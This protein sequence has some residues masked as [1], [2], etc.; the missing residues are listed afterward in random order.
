[1]SASSEKISNLVKKIS[2]IHGVDE[3]VISSD[4]KPDYDNF[5]KDSKLSFFTKNFNPKPGD[6]IVDVGCFIGSHLYAL[7]KKYPD[8]DF[9]G[10][11]IVPEYIE[12][13][14]AVHSS[15][16]CKFVCKN[17]LIPGVKQG[18]A[19][20]LFFFEVL[21]HVDSPKYYIDV[22][23]KILKK[24]GKLYLSTPAAIGITNILL[25]I[26]HQSFEYQESEQRDTGTE[27]DHIYIYGI[28]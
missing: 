16:N 14:K 19:D 25:N 13:A 12:L 22:F 8:C 26:K 27:K 3:N 17:I 1:M 5:A 4:I 21:E 9:I 15:S 7:S 18:S 24:N 23:Y 2:R 6:V 20:H 11:D 10:Y 28:S